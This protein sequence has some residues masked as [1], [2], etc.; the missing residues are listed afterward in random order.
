MVKQ[1]RCKKVKILL[2]IDIFMYFIFNLKAH[3]CFFN[4]LTRFTPLLSVSLIRL[5][6]FLLCFLAVSFFC[7]QAEAGPEERQQEDAGPEERQ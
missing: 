4:P 3:F 6:A 7:E 2:F 5:L 1:E